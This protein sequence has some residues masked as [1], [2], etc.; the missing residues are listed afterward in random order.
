MSGV[1]SVLEQRDSELYGPVLEEA[2]SLSFQIFIHA[3]LKESFY[4]EACHA[5]HEARFFVSL[6][7]ARYVFI[8][9]ASSL[10]LE[11]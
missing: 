9:K 4:A 11:N 3:I 7:S 2:V 8:L 6:Y 1:K 10:I 5:A